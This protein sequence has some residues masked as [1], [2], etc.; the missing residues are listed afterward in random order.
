MITQ[1]G[2]KSELYTEWINNQYYDFS[3]PDEVIGVFNWPNPS[4][5]T[6]ALGST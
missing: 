6:M 5:R 3:V 2:E 1:I 4:S